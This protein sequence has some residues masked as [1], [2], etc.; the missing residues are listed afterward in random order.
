[1]AEA[2]GFGGCPIFRRVVRELLEIPYVY[3][4]GAILCRHLLS[5]KTAQEIESS[6]LASML[7][8]YPIREEFFAVNVPVG[9]PIVLHARS[10]PRVYWAGLQTF[11]SEVVPVFLKL[12]TAATVVVD[13]GANAGVFSLLAFR[14]N[15]RLRIVAV[16]PNPRLAA[17]LEETFRRNAAL[18]QV[19][20][21]AMSDR[22]GSAR[23]SLNEGL[24]SIM[25]QRWGQAAVVEVPTFSFDDLLDNGADLVKI[26]AEGAELLILQGM[27]RSMEHDR[28]HILIEL[29]PESLRQAATLTR[30]LSYVLR[31]L[32][33]LV[34]CDEEFDLQVRSANF[35]ID[36]CG[37]DQCRHLATLAS[38]G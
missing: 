36:P 26:D 2:W 1:M 11:E 3:A 29:T 14:T 10:V 18:I 31:S 28:P 30:E 23:L 34:L 6:R 13:I 22:S 35:L 5:G 32:P 37:G 38:A 12:C 33:D 27:R 20:A 25:P 19:T 24:S 8:R 16:E 9:D 21:A 4:P 7:L 17:T 15:P